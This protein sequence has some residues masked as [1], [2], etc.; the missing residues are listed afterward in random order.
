[1]LDVEEVEVVREKSLVYLPKCFAK[2]YIAF[3]FTARLSD[4]AYPHSTKQR[5]QIL[6][7]SFPISLIR[8]L[9]HLFSDSDIEDAFYL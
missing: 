1:M 2:R 3:T 7:S 4:R 5:L 8:D 6:T 9:K